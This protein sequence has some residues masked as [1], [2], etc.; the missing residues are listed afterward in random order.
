MF[1]I[2]SYKNKDELLEEQYKAKYLKYKQKYLELN[3]TGGFLSS[4]GQYAILTN[5]VKAKEFVALFKI[6]QQS[7]GSSN[8]F[9]IEMG[10]LNVTYNI[11]FNGDEKKKELDLLIT[12][13]KAEHAKLIG[14]KKNEYTKLFNDFYIQCINPSVDKIKTI[15]HDSAYVI[16]QNT[17]ELNL[18]LTDSKA[19]LAAKG[20]AK[21]LASAGKKISNLFNVVN[22]DD[23]T[24]KFQFENIQKVTESQNKN[25]FNNVN[26][27]GQIK[28]NINTANSTRPKA[29]ELTHYVLVNITQEG[30]LVSKKNIISLDLTTLEPVLI[31]QPPPKQ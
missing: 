18:I 13:K 26:I 8:P 11:E 21:G 30:R 5:E 29:T 1:G 6:C 24:K 27:L 23:E 15:L 7:Q 12:N 3:Q 4:V 9:N 20:A 14:D 19:D 17:R 28:S 10:D 22:L 16:K 25:I 31:P 2:E